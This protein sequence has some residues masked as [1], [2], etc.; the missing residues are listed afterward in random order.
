GRVRNRQ[1]V[2]PVGGPVVTDRGS[3]GLRAVPIA[4]R[5]GQ[6]TAR[7][8]CRLAARGQ[9]ERHIRG[10]LARQPHGPTGGVASLLV[11]VRGCDRFEVDAG[12]IALR[13]R[14]GYATDRDVVVN[15]IAAGDGVSNRGRVN[16]VL[17]NLIVD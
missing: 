16:L 11:Q 14:G 5:E 2:I 13:D 9:S 4:R 3:H 15:R 17:G 1:Q 10:R 8:R 6:G 12:E 7:Q